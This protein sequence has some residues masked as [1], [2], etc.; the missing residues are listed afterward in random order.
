M[1]DGI[2]EEVIAVDLSGIHDDKKLDSLIPSPRSAKH[3]EL[4]SLYFDKIWPEVIHELK[5]LIRKIVELSRSTGLE[6]SKDEF[7][8]HPNIV[9]DEKSF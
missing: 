6:Y 8:N 5:P 1:F 4:V 7:K 9:D 2:L 3:D